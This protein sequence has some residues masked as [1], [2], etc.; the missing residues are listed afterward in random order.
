MLAGDGWSSGPV[1]EAVGFLD[2]WRGL[3]PN[4]KD[5]GLL[6]K[7]SSVHSFGMNCDLWVCGLRGM[8]VVAVRRLRPGRIVWLRGADA[9]LELPIDFEPPPVGLHLSWLDARP[10]DPL[11]HPDRQSG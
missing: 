2:R 11:R 9:I 6:L 1:R 7:T 3:W 10:T 5:C 8:R 4:P